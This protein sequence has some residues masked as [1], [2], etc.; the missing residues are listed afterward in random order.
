MQ[1]D[2]STYIW[3]TILL[4]GIVT[5]LIR[6]VMIQFLGK[7]INPKLSDILSFVPPAVLSAITF[8]GIFDDGVASVY[9][10]NPKIW[11]SIFALI[12][13]IRFKNV[14]ATILAGMS[15]LWL[16]HLL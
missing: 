5:F 3:G 1:I 15:F 10:S 11:A 6:V 4:C 14:V 12:I 8:H 7:Q 16:T 13:V 9:L 2:Q